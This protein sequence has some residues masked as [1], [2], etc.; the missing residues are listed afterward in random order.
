MPAQTIPRSGAWDKAKDA[1]KPALRAAGGQRLYTY[2]TEKY[3]WALVFVNY[4]A[5]RHRWLGRILGN[6]AW[7]DSLYIEGTNI[8]NARC[9]FCAYPQME[10]PKKTMP[11]EMFRRVIDEYAA[12]GGSEV[13]LTPIVGDPFVDKFLFERLDYLASVPTVRRFHFFTNAILIKHEH[14]ERLAAYGEKLTIY[15]SFGGFDRETYH[16]VMGVDKFDEAVA[17]IRGLIETKRRTGSRL[18]LQVNLRV[19]AGSERGE[20]WDY[21]VA[22]RSQGLIT[23]DGIDAYDSWAGMIAEP[24]LASAGLKARPMP[25]KR[26]P[27][28]RLITSPVVLADGRVNACACRDVEASLIVGDL[29]RESVGG[30]LSGKALHEL[31]ERHARGDFPEVCERCT[32]YDSLYP[33]WMRGRLFP[34]FSKLFG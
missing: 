22:A 34:F 9:V 12:A 28:H 17:G 4:L 3:R 6:A 2:L 20:F 31:L 13:D 15:N 16:R 21:L 18:G 25:V 26:G 8:C 33:S 19:P 14:L 1:V 10:R 32:Y 5:M 27:C 23:I 11:L 24:A 30:V 29:N 7:P